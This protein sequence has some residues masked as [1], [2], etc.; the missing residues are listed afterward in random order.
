MTLSQEDVMASDSDDFDNNTSALLIEVAA[1]QV[2][3]FEEVLKSDGGGKS[4][5]I[6]LMTV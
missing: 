5:E 1:G 2:A 6:K 4:S 3:T